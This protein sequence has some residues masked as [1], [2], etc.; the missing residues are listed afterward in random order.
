MTKKIN[1]KIISIFSRHKKQLP[2]GDDEKVIRNEDGFYYICIK[3]DENG[4]YF[5]AEKVLSHT[6]SCQYIVK[7]MITTTEHPYIYNYKVPGD[8]ILEFL[9][10]YIHGEKEGRVIEIDKYYPHELA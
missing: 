7:V 4:R 8:R 3:K 6:D 1:E 2:I 5:D 10:P 9:T